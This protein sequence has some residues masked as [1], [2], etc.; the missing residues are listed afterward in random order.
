MLAPH[1]RAAAYGLDTMYA[2]PA[3]RGYFRCFTYSDGQR[4]ALPP[5]IIESI[6]AYAER[7]GF[8]IVW[9]D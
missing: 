9:I 5:T 8:A 3:G 1:P 6:Q 4:V 7:H 2:E